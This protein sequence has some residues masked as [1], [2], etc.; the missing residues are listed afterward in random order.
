MASIE[1]LKSAAS[2]SQGFAMANLF[3]V[4]LPPLAG[5][6]SE[7]I[8]VICKMTE[9]PGRQIMSM[10]QQLGT[11]MRKVAS[12]YATTDINMSFYVMNDHAI[13]KYFDAWQK[14]AHDQ[15]TYRVNYYIDYVKDV[16]IKQLQKGTA[17]SL[18]KK[19]LGFLGGLP[20]SITGRLGN[21]GGID[22]GQGEIDIKIGSDEHVIRH[23]KLLEAYPTTVNAISLGND[24]EGISELSVQLSYR[25]WKSLEAEGPNN[26]LGDAL[27]GGLLKKIF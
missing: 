4:I 2:K 6:S 7:Q 16:E 1:Q 19:Q 12:G 5:V 3:Q 17:F 22:L 25:D 10:E 13:T 14:L 8:N 23:V 9:L 21:I 11:V 20:S 27:V 24:Q 18:F 15:D 26:N